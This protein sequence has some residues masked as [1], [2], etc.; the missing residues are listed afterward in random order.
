M[1][2]ASTIFTVIALVGLVGL[3]PMASYSAHD[4]QPDPAQIARGA[5]A[6]AE[7][8]GRCHNI[9]SPSELTDEEWLVSTTH[10]RVR[11][12]IPGNVIRDIQ[13]FLRSS[14]KKE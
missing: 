12:N 3:V 14:N 4:D 7:Q 2:K 1:K 10:M 6:W 8:C 13:A 5:K 9:R 11:G